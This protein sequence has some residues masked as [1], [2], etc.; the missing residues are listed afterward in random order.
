MP[1]FARRM[2]PLDPVFESIPFQEQENGFIVFN[3]KNR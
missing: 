3:P 1:V 2:I